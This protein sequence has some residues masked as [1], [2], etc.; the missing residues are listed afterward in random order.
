M[1]S[2]EPYHFSNKCASLFPQLKGGSYKKIVCLSDI[3][4]TSNS[5]FRSKVFT[6]HLDTESSNWNAIP[7]K[8]MEERPFGKDNFQVK[9]ISIFR[10]PKNVLGVGVGVGE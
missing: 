5:I 8:F 7:S 6:R 1:I 4:E 2:N 9:R 3:K 10:F